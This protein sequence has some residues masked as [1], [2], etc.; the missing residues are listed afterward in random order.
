MSSEASHAQLFRYIANPAKVSHQPRKTAPE[1]TPTAV[2]PEPVSAPISQ[3]EP[4]TVPISPA[5]PD[6][7]NDT[8]APIDVFQA[9]TQELQNPSLFQQAVQTRQ[10]ET[11]LQ[12]QPEPAPA[13]SQP[14]KPSEPPPAVI[15]EVVEN[16]DESLEKQ[17]CLLE[18]QRL[19]QQGVQLTRNFNK[20]DS[21]QSL[22]FELRRKLMEQ[23]EVQTVNMLRDGMS[24]VFTGI[25]MA[26]NRFGPIL[27]LNGW[28]AHVSKDMARF[29][30]PLSRMYRKYY[31]KSQMSPEAE[32]LCAIVA[33]AVMFHVSKKFSGPS[34]SFP[35][36]K[37]SAPAF[38]PMQFASMFTSMA[39][40]MNG[41]HVNI[42]KP[43][44]PQSNAEG[45][46]PMGVF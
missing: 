9:S 41:G 30:Q 19:Q 37:P 5:K 43:S 12:P 16:I 36:S 3:P 45:P 42:S 29:E 32:V 23:Q 1:T 33:S 27:D 17:A 4:E 40:G 44:A 24:L 22:Q 35:G 31:R 21:L 7:F 46:P 20:D 14:S 26:N 2:E 10:Q 18:L 6:K 13:A 39:G 25:E 38:N 8:Q 15:P 11:N 34:V 28:A